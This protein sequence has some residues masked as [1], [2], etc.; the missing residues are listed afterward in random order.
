M[1]IA[2]FINK[3]TPIWDTL[4]KW[5]IGLVVRPDHFTGKNRTL[6]FIV[7]DSLDDEEYMFHDCISVAMN[8]ATMYDTVNGLSEMFGTK[9]IQDFV[10]AS[11]QYSREY[12]VLLKKFGSEYYRFAIAQIRYEMELEGFR[13]TKNIKLDYYRAWRFFGSRRAIR[14]F[15]LDVLLVEKIPKCVLCRHCRVGR[16]NIRTCAKLAVECD[17]SVANH[18]LK[19][20]LKTGRFDVSNRIEDV[21]DAFRDGEC[22]SF[23]KRGERKRSG[24]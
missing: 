7:D 24:H 12:Q 23:E 11:N 17:R 9:W 1:S 19:V 18:S 3:M 13:F 4:D 8:T 14:K 15:M 21:L 2:G 20:I 6:T 22:T 16:N 5:G 10:W